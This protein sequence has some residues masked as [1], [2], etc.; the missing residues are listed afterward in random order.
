MT[1][2]PEQEP[3]DVVKGKVAA[4]LSERELAINVGSTGGVKVGM[5]FKILADAAQVC[6]PDTNEVLGTVIREKVRVEAVKVLERMSI[7]RTYKATASAN[8]DAA[9]AS[10]IRAMNAEHPEKLKAEGSAYLSSLSEEES[11]VKRGDEVV[12]LTEHESD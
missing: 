2:E 12:Q 8:I 7:C 3:R 11:Y 5:R 1:K 9:L 6:D 4:V 10:Y